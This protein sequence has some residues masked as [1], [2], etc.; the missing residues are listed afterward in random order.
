MISLSVGLL[1]PSFF[2]G[3]TPNEA[4]IQPVS[5]A[6]RAVPDAPTSQKTRHIGAGTPAGRQEGKIRIPQFRLSSLRTS[7]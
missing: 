5:I 2:M 4:Q 1:S 7:R 3:F 6:D